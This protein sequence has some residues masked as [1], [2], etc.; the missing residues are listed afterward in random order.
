MDKY[1]KKQ[2]IFYAA[3]GPGDLVESH[4]R[5][6]RREHNPTEVSITFSSQIQDFCARLG[7]ECYMLSTHSR[8]E[9]V[10]DGDFTIEHRPK[11]AR[12]GLRFHLAEVAYG[13]GLLA[14]ALKFRARFALLDSGCTHFF[15]IAL[16][17][18]FGIRV[19]P[20]LHNTLWPSGFPPTRPVPRLVLWFD[21]FFWK[22][23]P[24]AAIAVS[25]ECE[26]QVIAIAGRVCYPIRQ[27]RAQFRPE[28]FTNIPPPPPHDRRPFRVM[29]IGRVERIKGVF[30]LL[31]MARR[32]EDSH[33]G[34]V[35]WE[36]C[37]RGKDFEELVKRHQ[38]LG[39]GDTVNLRGW[40]SLDD[41]IKVYGASHAC[42]VPTRSSFTEGLA[43][44]A[45]EAILS[46][47]PLV[48]NPVVPALELLR[49]ACVEAK[50][51][52]PE[53]HMQAVLRLATDGDLYRRLCVAC[54]GL[55]A[56]F[57]DSRRYGLTSVLQT[58][59]DEIDGRPGR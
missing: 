46:G 43:M 41:L 57:Y 48:T 20:I 27:I 8:R 18:L 23:I 10:A 35:R 31:E 53:S 30:D 52:D 6:K 39:L 3:S 5:W 4:R 50:T 29:F 24:S 22:W 45:A 21:T 59:L 12:H 55:H 49:S 32:I 7:A 33:P 37:G 38:Q 1:Q 16:F 47:R 11:P 13:L 28:Y 2:R 15:V 44:T 25:P 34:L 19:I 56:Q 42:I 14:T 58:V 17:R 36:I 51:D 54:A 40:T 9:I 26:R